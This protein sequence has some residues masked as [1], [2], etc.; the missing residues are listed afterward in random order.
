MDLDN[1]GKEWKY[2]PIMDQCFT[3]ENVVFDEISFQKLFENVELPYFK[4]IENQLQQIKSELR[5][6]DLVQR[7]QMMKILLNKKRTKNLWQIGI[8]QRPVA[9]AEFIQAGKSLQT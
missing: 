3:S 9:D 5:R 7:Q 6:Y 1:K 8:Y 2:C 4:E